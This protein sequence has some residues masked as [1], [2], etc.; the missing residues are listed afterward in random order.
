[1]AHFQQK[2]PPVIP[3]TT[4]DSSFYELSIPGHVDVLSF[5]PSSN[6]TL[7]QYFTCNAS[8]ALASHSFVHQEVCELILPMALE[9][10]ALL[11]ATLALAAIHRTSLTSTIENAFDDNARDLV[12]RLT[13]T[14][15]SF[16]RKDLQEPGSSSLGPKMATIRTLFLCEAIS[17]SPTLQAWRSH[18]LGAKAL[19]S[20]FDQHIGQPGSNADSSLRFLRRWY[21]ITEALVALTPEGLA[22]GQIE[23]FGPQPL[24][25]KLSSQEICIDAYTGCAED[26]SVAFREIGAVAWERRLATEDPDRFPRLSEE[27]FHREADHLELSVRE[28]IERDK[29]HTNPVNI[30]GAPTLSVQ[31]LREFVLCNEAYQQTALI[32]VHRR[33]RRLSST[34]IP[35]QECVGRIVECV[36]SIRPAAT[37]SPLTLLT[38]PL[39]TA[40]CEAQGP[41]RSKVSWLLKSMYSHLRLPNMKRALEVLEAFWHESEDSDIGWESFSRTESPCLH[42]YFQTLMMT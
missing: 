31:E 26:L 29:S 34:S 22:G 1:M 35:V 24:S 9:N 5:I 13:A 2:P 36:G 6:R 14:S 16:L 41:A 7:L 40:G 21:N 28:M 17:G 3:A 15:I 39:F 11:Y 4:Q 20:S 32:H 23:F 10:Q 37:L 12:T 8:R 42:G 38:T 30:A 19:L 18:F 27:D 25:P 33:I